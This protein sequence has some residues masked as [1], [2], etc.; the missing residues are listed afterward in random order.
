MAR[1]LLRPVLDENVSFL[2]FI[3]P[4]SLSA[5]YGGLRAGLVSTVISAV[6]ADY[7]FVQPR[8][9]LAINDVQDTA[10]LVIFLFIGGLVSWL[11]ERCLTGERVA[12]R[13]AEL[14]QDTNQRLEALVQ[15][16]PLAIMVLDESARVQLWNPA[17]ERIFGWSKEEVIEQPVPL[18]P[19]ERFSEFQEI[20]TGRI[21]SP[22]LKDIT[23]TEIR[24]SRKDGTPMDAD[25]WAAPLG[26]VLG[27]TRITLCILADITARKQAEQDRSELLA[28]E[29]AARSEAETANRMK[30]EFLAT[31]SHELRTP[32]NAILGW[33]RLLHS[34]QL[35]QRTASRALESVERNAKVQAKLIEDLLD[36]SRIITGKLRLEIKPVDIHSVLEVTVETFRP[37]AEAKGISLQSEST[38]QAAIV[39]A[40]PN[41][42]QQVLWNLLSNAVKFTPKGGRIHI[43]VT[44]HET[45][46]EISVTDTGKG[47][48]REFLPYVFERFRQADGSLTRK[49]GGLGLGLAI[50]RHLTELHGGTVRVDSPGPGQGSVFMVKLPLLTR[51]DVIVSSPTLLRL[52]ARE[53]LPIEFTSVLSGVRLLVV[54]DEPNSRELLVTLLTHCGADV[55]EACS[56]AQALAEVTRFHPDLLISDIEMPEEDGYSLIRKLRSMEEDLGRRIAGVA[57]TAHARTEDR[58]RALEAGYDTHVSKPVEPSEFV[59][60]IASLARRS[61]RKG[62][63]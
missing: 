14:L 20:S 12:K 41:R 35:D 32:L 37:T 31:I 39:L 55:K 61:K 27:T 6:V 10:Q 47:I 36:V 30:D 53:E 7:F 63:V 29:Q 42:L 60:V 15:A 48:A 57:L 5:W 54:D 21:P 59:T 49:H 17:A 26:P 2:I 4:V 22:Q 43:R 25:L 46:A 1:F 3:L 13:S 28:R 9:S 34:G 58:L 8:H 24:C 50:V 16:S 19:R 51:K 33:A 18:I 62:A 38:P 52:T 23:E 11:S 40:D 56:A 44:T 45:Q